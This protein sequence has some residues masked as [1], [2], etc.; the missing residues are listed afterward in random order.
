[1]RPLHGDETKAFFEKL[2]NYIGSENIK[3]QGSENHYIFSKKWLIWAKIRFSY[4]N[5]VFVRKI[6]DVKY[7]TKRYFI[8]ENVFWIYFNR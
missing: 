5:G 8:F 6:S 4:W 7:R 3:T 2:A 1:M